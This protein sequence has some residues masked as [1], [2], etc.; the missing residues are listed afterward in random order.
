MTKDKPQVLLE[1]HLKKLKLP[2]I[3]REHQAIAANCGKDRVTYSG[4]LLQ[5]VERELIDREC[6]AGE[7]RIKSA[8]FP[9]LKTMDQFDFKAQISINESLIRELLHGE[10]I[11]KKENI[12]F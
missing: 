4:Y 5:L 1:H 7:R 9:I 10:Y 8:R 2:T 6:R 12:L 11:M 3:L